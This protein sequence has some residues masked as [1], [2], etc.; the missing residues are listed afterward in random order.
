MFK[1]VII[2]S[3]KKALVFRLN[4]KIWKIKFGRVAYTILLKQAIL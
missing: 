2:I 3:V 4:V 1:N